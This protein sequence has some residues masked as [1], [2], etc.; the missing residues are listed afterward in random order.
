MSSLY[1]ISRRY[2]NIEA[3]LE[4]ENVSQEMIVLAL[5]TVEDSLQA[6]CEN[7]IKMLVSIDDTLANV[8]KRIKELKAYQATLEN[9]KKRIDYLF[10]NTLKQLKKDK[11][12][13]SEG[14]M[15]I[16]KNPEH[17]V[18]DNITLVPAKYQRQKIMVDLDKVAI[19]RDLKLGET[20]KGCHLEQTER[21]VY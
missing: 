20:V 3:M 12:T 18:V 5:E 11:V 19:K 15:K 21:L 6:K 13:T 17:V 10:T 8:K 9:R 4:D 2:K 14:E 16:R 7:G 1:D